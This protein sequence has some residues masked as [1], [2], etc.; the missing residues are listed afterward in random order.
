M[1]KTPNSRNGCSKKT[2]KSEFRPVEL[3]ILRE[4]NG[5]FEPKIISKYQRNIT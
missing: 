5:E 3:I 1:R 4:R 2:V